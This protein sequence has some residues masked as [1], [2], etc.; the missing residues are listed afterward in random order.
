MIQIMES[1]CLKKK[2]TYGIKSNYI[3]V[4]RLEKTYKMFTTKVLY[5]LKIGTTRI[6]FMELSVGCGR[7]GGVRYN[8]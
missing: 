4:I 2:K 7:W 8:L 5:S 1:K 6:L 3:S